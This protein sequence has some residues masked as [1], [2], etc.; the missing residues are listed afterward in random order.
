MSNKLRIFINATLM[1]AAALVFAAGTAA[2]AQTESVLYDF[3]ALQPNPA[4]GAVPAS[5][6][7]VDPLGNLYGSAEVGGTFGGGVIYKIVLDGGGTWS[8]KVVHNF[9]TW[10]SGASPF[11]SLTLDGAGNVYGVTHQGGNSQQCGIAG[12]GTVFEMTPNAGDGWTVTFLHSFSESKADGF[13]P[14]G[15]LTVDAAG[16]VFGTTGRG[17]TGVCADYSGGPAG[18]CGTVYELSPGARG[19]WSAKIIHSFQGA[20]LG[21]PGPDGQAPAGGLVFDRV[22][23]LYGTTTFGGVYGYGTVYELS[24][25]PDGTWSSKILHSF[26][27]NGADGYEPAGSLIFR[28]DGSLYGTTQYGGT[29]LCTNYSGNEVIGCGTVFEL[30]PTRNGHWQETIAYSFEDNAT[31]GWFPVGTLT[32]DASGNLYGTTPEGGGSATCNYNGVSFGCGTVFELAPANG[33]GWTQTVLHSF[34]LDGI[35]GQ[36]PN[37]TLA[38]DAEG[39]IFGTTISGG[40]NWK[41]GGGTVFEITP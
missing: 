9:E 6:L 8:Q 39:N 19:K 31:D 41:S 20:V 7:I 25:K 26:N 2:V 21:A 5:G 33:E 24:P 18:T 35:D 17:G 14:N 3:A 37:S 34:Q 28:A 4:G 30:S 11:G 10:P 40:V 23:N 12:C 1:M 38:L 15:G 29:G 32:F 36:S 16:N 22:G 27:H 13:S